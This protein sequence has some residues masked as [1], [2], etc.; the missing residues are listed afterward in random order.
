MESGARAPRLSRHLPTLLLGL[1]VLAS[2]AL[3]LGLQTGLTFF[4]DDFAFLL[5]RP[6]VSPSSVFPPHGEHIVVLP[7]LIYRALIEVFGMSTA[8]PEK[9]VQT[10]LLAV[11]GVLLFV[12][13]RRRVGAWVALSTAVIILF[14][15]P[16]W[17]VLE[18]DFEM[19][20]AGSVATGL[21]MLL[22]LERRDR[23]GDIAACVLLVA[24]IAFG[25][26]GVAF[27]AG[28]LVDV[29][30]RRGPGWR[31][32]WR[33][34]YVPGVGLFLYGI[35]Y[36]GY[37]RDA[38]STLTWHNVARSPAYLFDGVASSLDS[39]VGLNTR[40]TGGEASTG[41]PLW[42]RPLLVAL[43]AVIVLLWLPGRQLSPRFWVVG[44]I[45]LAFWLLAAF[46]FI[47]GREPEASRYMYMGAI[48]LVLALA[49]VFDGVHLGCRGNA[50]L[51]IATVAIVASNLVFLVDGKRLLK[52][53]TQL[54]RA[55][56]G[57]IEIARDTVHPDFLLD[58]QFSGT[59]SL[60]DVTASGYFAAADAHGT[61]ADSPA[62]IF[63]EP[64]A[65]RERADDVLVHAL[66]VGLF[67]D[68][69][70]RT[71]GGPPRV[72]GAAATKAIRSGSC[73][74]LPAGAGRR[75]ARVEVS[76]PG[77]I[78]H[79]GVGKPAKL[80]IR[81]FSRTAF[82]VVLADLAGS[83]SAQLRIPRDRSHVPWQ[84]QIAASQAVRVCGGG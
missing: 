25:S 61:P 34:L 22:A 37:A 6:D 42:G 2:S 52:S 38:Q 27:A 28:A 76:P 71:A 67:Q 44:A 14:F 33:R 53:Q 65:V 66:G 74:V 69:A 9:V 80:R 13:A 1:A 35:W 54:A 21:A 48:L 18:W 46:F 7:V 78:I 8:F 77:P 40:P 4:Q 32:G 62:Q 10:T 47:P 84:L 20:Y 23:S 11:S 26:V 72:L 82:P 50:A 19:G 39:L 70:G 24:S 29:W 83:S 43:I 64:E 49:E 31:E 56:L 30:L 79:V 60:I 51:A 5:K 15:G 55:D 16:A 73:T 75:G 36:L 57:A 63:S 59:A 41:G 68:A 12:Y 58:P 17:D 81:R 45:G 3:L